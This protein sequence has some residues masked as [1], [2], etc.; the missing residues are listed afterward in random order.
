MYI[1]GLK[2]L[3][4]EVDAKYIK[5]MINNPDSQPN[6]TINRLIAGILLFNFKLRHVVGKDHAPADGLSR[7][8]KAEN[9]PPNDN[10]TESWIDQACSFSMECLN[11]SVEYQNCGDHLKSIMWPGHRVF[12]QNSDKLDS[13]TLKIPRSEKVEDRDR[14]LK[15]IEGFLRDPTNLSAI[16][17]ID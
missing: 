12:I 7:R 4:V 2:N 11:L 16:P 14:H 15:I 13:G 9:D 5:G 3:V 1:V 10:N 6:A 17:K 8:R